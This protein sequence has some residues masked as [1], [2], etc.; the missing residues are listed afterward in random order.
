MKVVALVSGGKDSIYN[1]MK[2][3]EHGHEIVC[4]ANLY[5]A[6]VEI[7]DLDSWMYQTVGHEHIQVMAH[8]LDLPLIRQPVRGTSTVQTLD[9]TPTD[10][11]EV[12]DLLVL[13]Q[14]VKRAY[15]EVAAVATG[16]ILSTYQRLRVEKVCRRLGLLSLAYLWQRDQH[17]LL[18]EMVDRGVRAMLIKIAAMGLKRRHLGKTLDEVIDELRAME[19]IHV[20]GEG[21]EFESFVIGCPLFKRPMTVLE[22]HA[23]MSDDN[24]IAPVGVWK[25]GVAADGALPPDPDPDPEPTPAPA[26]PERP[27]ILHEYSPT[28][29]QFTRAGNVLFLGGLSVDTVLRPATELPV[30]LQVHLLLQYTNSR[31]QALGRETRHIF[32]VHVYAKR[33]SDFAAINAAYNTYFGN[34][35][36]SR[37]TVGW[38][39]QCSA[40]GLVVLEVYARA[41]NAVLLDVDA[42]VDSAQQQ[43]EEDTDFES[44]H[45]QSISEWAPACV[46]PYSQAWRLKGLLYFAGIIGL[47]PETM[48]LP[49]ADADGENES[50]LALRSL[51]RVAEVMRTQCSNA[52]SMIIYVTEWGGAATAIQ[53]WLEVAGEGWDRLVRVVQVSA[54]P[55]GCTVE[56][57]MVAT[58]PHVPVV[59]NTLIHIECKH[60]TVLASNSLQV[61]SQGLTL[62]H[63]G[64]C[65]LPSADRSTLAHEVVRAALAAAGGACTTIGSLRCYQSTRCSITLQVPHIVQELAAQCAQAFARPSPSSTPPTWLSRRC[66][67]QHPTWRWR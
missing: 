52:L 50:R 1:M 2:C 5:P 53:H 31:L 6:D 58:L 62:T 38:D 42:N 11:D 16:A 59:M 61:P 29:P 63:L 54:L 12:E 56:Y 32:F 19:C 15:P 14:C 67:R 33:M 49:P 48:T 17:E 30:D 8:C 41:S 10:S 57:Q 55:R 64:L 40:A 66:G 46:G 37:A 25:F 9:Y 22:G 7:D 65:I 47:V 3:L 13:L 4:L 43:R 35:P 20:C 23:L 60:I 39:S 36:P 24:P 45:V 51:T 34:Q 44:L 26:A 27:V 18:Q 21:G 28:A